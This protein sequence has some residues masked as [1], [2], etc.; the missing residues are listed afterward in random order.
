MGGGEIQTSW[1]LECCY[2]EDYS[3]SLC[4][5]CHCKHYSI[6][7]CTEESTSGHTTSKQR[8]PD[9]YTF[10]CMKCLS[11]DYHTSRLFHTC[12][13]QEQFISCRQ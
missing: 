13:H 11:S 7:M 4:S 3:K 5:S 9:S 1:K 8:P 12:D 10:G 6:P 2:I